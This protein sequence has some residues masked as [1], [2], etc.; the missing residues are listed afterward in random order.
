M[1]VTCAYLNFVFENTKT[2]WYFDN[3]R[4]N[5]ISLN[6]PCLEWVPNW[7]V[8]IDACLSADVTRSFRLQDKN[9]LLNL[10]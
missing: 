8:F 9:I 3:R 4:Q 1:I 2:K 10:K 5:V 6:Q 7:G